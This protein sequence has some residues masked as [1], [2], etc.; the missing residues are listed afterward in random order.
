MINHYLTGVQTRKT[1]LLNKKSSATYVEMHAYTANAHNIPNGDWIKI[2]NDRGKVKYQAKIIDSI[3]RDTLFVVIHWENEECV[4]L[5]TSLNLDPISKIH[6]VV[7]SLILHKL[8]LV[9]S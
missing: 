1:S 6:I 7:Y 2:S 5:L 8:S 3:R 9:N 4:N